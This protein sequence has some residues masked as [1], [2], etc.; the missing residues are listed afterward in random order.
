MPDQ[1]CGWP[2]LILAAQDAR[3]DPTLDRTPFRCRAIHTHSHS[4]SLGQLRHANS[5]HVH[6]SG[7][8]EDTEVLRE[9]SRHGEKVQITQTVALAGNLFFFL[10]TSYNKMMLNKNS[11]V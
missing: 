9:K 6:I 11:T 2:E 4:L 10:I 7:M 8:W 3:W 5:P 1:G